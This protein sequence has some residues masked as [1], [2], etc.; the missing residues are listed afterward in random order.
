ML[1]IVAALAVAA[2]ATQSHVAVLVVHVTRVH[3]EA[4]IEEQFVR[5]SS[6]HDALFR[7]HLTVEALKT[8][9][10]AEPSSMA[11][12]RRLM[13]EN[14]C[15]SV[16]ELSTG[17]ALKCRVMRGTR[18]ASI[19][20]RSLASAQR[21]TAIDLPMAWLPHV[22]YAVVVRASRKGARKSAGSKAPA[23]FPG[24]TQNPHSIRA[25]YHVPAAG[26]AVPSNFSQG[27]GEFEGEYFLQSDVNEFT[28]TFGLQSFNVSVLGPNSPNPNSDSIEGTLDVQYMA[29]MSNGH[30]PTWWLEQSTNHQEPG[31]IDFHLWADKVMRMAHVPAVVSLSWGAGY[32]NYVSDPAIF[33]ADNDAFRKMGLIGVSVMAA[34]G[35][36][37]PGVRSEFFN[38]NT[39]T[40][41]WPASSPYVT[42]VGATYAD[43]S[44]G[45]EMSVSFSGGGF[46]TAFT[47]PSWQAASIAAYLQSTTVSLPN[48]SFYNATGRGYPD[49]SALGTNYDICVNGQWQNVSGT[50][51][52]SPVF[53]GIIALIAAER[54]SSGQP[55][56]GFLNP[57]LYQLGKVGFDVTQGASQYTDCFGIP[58]PGFPATVGWDA[59]SGLGTPDFAYL[60]KN[61]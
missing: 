32:E 10:A 18:M 52:A 42:S 37:G 46:S 27:V 45:V 4:E 47:A 8:L 28:T 26:V 3:S 9:V 21:R 24:V 15:R 56:L 39:F 60:S 23:G 41:S 35:D 43:P 38:C 34:S 30:V 19:V 50:S 11:A 57:K 14:G 25:R 48:A 54:A 58:L 61:L 7:Q 12:V 59:V 49:V 2:V 53:A 55:A 1:A 36:S 6:P 5:R 44:T 51:C 20:R 22:R 31:N 16:E 40:P 13:H 17:D 29:A 33:D